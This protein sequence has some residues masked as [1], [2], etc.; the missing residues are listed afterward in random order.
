MSFEA[1]QF[2]LL[3]ATCTANRSLK[4]LVNVINTLNQY[5][6]EIPNPAFIDAKQSLNTVVETA[7]EHDGIF[8][9][10]FSLAYHYPKSENYKFDLG[11]MYANQVAGKVKLAKKKKFENSQWFAICAEIV[12]LYNALMLLKDKVVKRAVRSEEERAEDYVP[13]IPQTVSAALVNDILRNMTD[14]LTTNY[15]KILYNHFVTM[16]ESRIARPR[17]RGEAENLAD[18]LLQDVGENWDSRTGN[19]TSLNSKWK[20]MLA[21]RADGDA[22]YAQN[23]FLYKGVTK[24]AVIVEN[25]ANFDAATVLKGEVNYEGFHGEVR[26]NFTDGTNFVIRTKVV[27]K[28]SIHGKP[29]N[30]YPMTFHFVTGMTGQPSHEEMIEK[31]SKG[32]K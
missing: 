16:V 21:V 30:Q 12:T 22:K 15:A 28:Y 3:T 8:G 27:S 32:V 11:F 1:E 7:T 26:F 14:D 24:L 31:F 6:T 9:E 18:I 13:P 23:M 20:A 4:A 29:F 5:S 19:Y 25:K 17:V 10:I 2:P